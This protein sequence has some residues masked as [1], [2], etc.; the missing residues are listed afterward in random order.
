MGWRV[1]NFL[2]TF[3]GRGNSMSDSGREDR[4]STERGEP[5]GGAS[6][7]LCVIVK[8]KKARSEME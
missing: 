6:V 8:K 7:D 2:V 3:Q 4:G 5:R 1:V